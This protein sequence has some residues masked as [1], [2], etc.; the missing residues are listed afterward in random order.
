[1][2][3]SRLVGV[4]TAPDLAPQANKNLNGGA[5]GSSV[6]SCCVL[7]GSHVQKSVTESS[8]LTGDF[9]SIGSRKHRCKEVE[10]VIATNVAQEAWVGTYRVCAEYW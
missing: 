5:V 1:M 7:S 10:H 6:F 4:A 8:L 9:G 2:A 3:E